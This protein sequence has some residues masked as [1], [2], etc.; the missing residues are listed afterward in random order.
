MGIKHFEVKHQVTSSPACLPQLCGVRALIRPT[1]C[2]FFGC[3]GWDGG[4]VHLRMRPKLL[5]IGSQ[6]GNS[7]PPCSWL[8]PRASHAVG[9]VCAQPRHAQRLWCRSKADLT[10]WYCLPLIPRWKPT[11]WK[12]MFHWE[13]SALTTT[14]RPSQPHCQIGQR[15]NWLE[16]CKVCLAEEWNLAPSIK[17]H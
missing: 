2:L 12:W 16:S 7:Q 9:L 3:L 5:F 1:L 15:K 13:L 14:C 4:G 11:P 17:M 6:N 10:K 8:Q